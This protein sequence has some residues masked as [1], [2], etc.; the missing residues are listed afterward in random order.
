VLIISIKYIV[1]LLQAASVRIFENDRVQIGAAL[2]GVLIGV[3]LVVPIKVCLLVLS[4]THES[5]LT[6]TKLYQ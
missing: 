4:C 5:R 1:W 6:C 3:Y 2:D